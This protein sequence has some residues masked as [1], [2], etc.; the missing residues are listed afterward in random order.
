VLRNPIPLLALLA[1]CGG[2]VSDELSSPDASPAGSHLGELDAG[3]GA[4]A[5]GGG[6]ASMFDSGS[7]A[8]S[9]GD[10]SQG[11]GDGGPETS[12]ADA[13]GD[14]GIDAS[15]NAED[16]SLSAEGG[17][18]CG[19]GSVGSS[20]SPQP[21]GSCVPSYVPTVHLQ[22]SCTTQDVSFYYDNCMGTCDDTDLGWAQCQYCLA[23]LSSPECFDCLSNQASASPWGV[24][25]YYGDVGY[26]L[27]VAG[28]FAAIGA[29]TACVTAEEELTE[30]TTAA[31]WATCEAVSATVAEGSACLAAAQEGECSSYAA[32]ITANCPAAILDAS[33]CAAPDDAGVGA[34]YLTL[35]QTMCE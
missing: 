14:S 28:C 32:A 11:A 8:A 9:S 18:N 5:D 12:L 13:G 33:A 25:V 10:A 3:T 19:T 6:D 16:A 2:E 35:A 26:S 4:N 23:N 7:D 30:C 22:G 34:N 15:P 20:C 17:S 1:A 31:C 27:D 21:L 24:V 29:S